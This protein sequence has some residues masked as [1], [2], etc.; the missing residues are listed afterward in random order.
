MKTRQTPAKKRTN[1]PT[2]HYEKGQKIQRLLL[3]KTPTR[4]TRNNQTLLNISMTC[5]L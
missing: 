1:K 2:K 4:S 3:F 5:T